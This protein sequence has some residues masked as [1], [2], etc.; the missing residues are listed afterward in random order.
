MYLGF[1]HRFTIMG[2]AGSTPGI[3]LKS[4]GGGGCCAFFWAIC[5][6]KPCN[7]VAAAAVDGALADANAAPCC[8]MMSSKTPMTSPQISAGRI[9]QVYS[10]LA[11]AQSSAGRPNPAAIN[12]ATG[13]PALGSG[14]EVC[15]HE[16]HN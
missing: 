10:K 5:W 12:A 2:D 8:A 6:N 13:S 3:G 15:A 7:E 4:F 9:F 16:I 1:V 14:L 11:G